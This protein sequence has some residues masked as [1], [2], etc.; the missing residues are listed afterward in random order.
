VSTPPPPHI[1]IVGPGA[2]GC[3][4]AVRLGNH[5][6][7]VTLVGRPGSRAGRLAADGLW[8]EDRSGRRKE[9]LTVRSR[10][11]ASLCLDAH[12]LAV[13]VKSYDTAAVVEQLRG[14][15][16]SAPVLVFQNGLDGPGLVADA[17][18]AHRVFGAVTEQGAMRRGENE[19]KHSGEGLTRIAPFRPN[20][21]TQA[22]CQQLA[23]TL[24]RHGLESKAEHHLDTL[25]WQKAMVNTAINAMAALLL[26]PNGTLLD[27]AAAVE[28]GDRAARETSETAQA[29]GH[30]LETPVEAWR[31]V[32]QATAGNACSTLQDI[33]AGRQTEIDAIN[34]AVARAAGAVGVAAP[35][36]QMLA[37]LIAAREDTAPSSTRLA[38]LTLNTKGAKG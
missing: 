29:L 31:A 37:G 8:F 14:Q 7:R 1:V 10:L 9:P 15:P 28:L 3:L 25:L 20:K 30:D 5:G 16:G 27:S 26:V 18:G 34:G 33:I 6:A 36:N 19:L 38:R 13:C 35:V 12:L 17:L 4:F 24:S 21:D 22:R 32:A 11:D 23:E 2:L